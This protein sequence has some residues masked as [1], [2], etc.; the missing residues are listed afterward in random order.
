ML[1]VQRSL[2]RAAMN[3]QPSVSF[4]VRSSYEESGSR[5]L[6]S[7]V[8]AFRNHVLVPVPSPCAGYISIQFVVVFFLAFW[9]W[10]QF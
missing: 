2:P 3:I 9:R 10:K 7:V 5:H 8:R 4:F 6:D 1:S